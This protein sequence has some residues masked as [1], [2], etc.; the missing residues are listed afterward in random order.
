M[1]TK[2]SYT[3]TG[4]ATGRVSGTHLFLH[5]SFLVQYQWT[6]FTKTALSRLL[7][8]LQTSF[9]THPISNESPYSYIGFSAIG[10]VAHPSNDFYQTFWDNFC[11]SEKHHKYLKNRCIWLKKHHICFKE[12]RISFKKHHTCLNMIITTIIIKVCQCLSH[13]LH[14]GGLRAGRY[15]PDRDG[16]GW[17]QEGIQRYTSVQTEECKSAAGQAWRKAS[18]AS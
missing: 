6:C 8:E 9:C 4:Q 7:C 14:R 2:A 12:Y 15:T 5:I 13:R 17:A 3:T 16:C 18:H 11:M 1:Y 10:F